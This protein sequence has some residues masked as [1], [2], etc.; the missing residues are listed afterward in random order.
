M[1]LRLVLITLL[2]AM[3][4]LAQSPVKDVSHSAAYWRDVCSGDRQGLSR[5]DQQKMCE[6]YLSSFHDAADEYADAGHKLFCAPEQLSAET[7]RRDFLAYVVEIPETAEF[8]PAGRALVLA[9]MRRYPCAVDANAQAAARRG[10]E[11]ALIELAGGDAPRGVD[12]RI[13][14]GRRLAQSDERKLLLDHG[15]EHDLGQL[16]ALHLAEVSEAERAGLAHD[17]GREIGF[18]FRTH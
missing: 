4:A 2:A 9:L 6:L 16:V 5:L 7:M 8:F 17:E 11:S 14:G 13:D 3:P 1:R 12:H 10:A 15:A 18:G